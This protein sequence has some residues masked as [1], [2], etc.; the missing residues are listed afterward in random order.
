MTAYSGRERW[1]AAF[2]EAQANGQIRDADFT[3]LSGVEVDPVYGPQDEDA[4]DRMERIGWP[5]ELPSPVVCTRVAIAGAP[6][7]S[8]S[9][10]ASA[11]PIRPTSVTR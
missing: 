11:T 7:P 9:L 5:G 2:A 8:G 10:P 4:D 1:A 6:G 3:T